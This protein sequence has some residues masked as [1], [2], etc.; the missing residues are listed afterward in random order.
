[1]GWQL[2]GY[3]AYENSY[4][5]NFSPIHST[6]A[7]MRCDVVCLSNS[8]TSLSP[9]GIPPPPLPPSWGL[10]LHATARQSRIAPWCCLL[11]GA[12]RVRS[13]LSLSL[14]FSV[15]LPLSLLSGCRVG[16]ERRAC[17]PG[18]RTQLVRPGPCCCLFVQCKRMCECMY[19][20][21]YTYTHHIH[22]MLCTRAHTYTKIRPSTVFVVPV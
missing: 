21:V 7:S 18:Q 5:S 6:S 19:V 11:R 8:L 20:C 22:N 1:M 3:N 15:S 2:Q 14:S 9:C 13:S 17:C 10:H 16:G 12:V 4:P